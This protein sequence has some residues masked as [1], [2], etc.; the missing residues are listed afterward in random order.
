MLIRF[1]EITTN[2]VGGVY[3]KE[4]FINPSTGLF[5]KTSDIGKP[6]TLVLQGEYNFD[7]TDN[8]SELVIEV[9]TPLLNYPNRITHIVAETNQVTGS[10]NSIRYVAYSVDSVEYMGFS[11]VKFLLVE[12]P[13]ISHMTQ[14]VDSNMLINR[15]NDYS[16]FMSHDISDLAYSR[17]REDIDIGVYDYTG[18]WV[19][20]TLAIN[21]DDVDIVYIKFRDLEPDNYEQFSTLGDV[22]VKYPE[23]V[24]KSPTAIDYYGKIVATGAGSLY[25]AQYIYSLNK[26]VWRRIPISVPASEVNQR[27]VMRKAVTENFGW[28]GPSVKLITGDMLTLNFAF[29]IVDNIMSYGVIG[30]DESGT[31]YGYNNIPCADRLE[32]FQIGNV[33]MDS[34]IISKR[35]VT[36]IAFNEQGNHRP[37][38]SDG[39]YLYVKNNNLVMSHNWSYGENGELNTFVPIIKNISSIQKFNFSITGTSKVT[40]HEPFANYYLNVFGQNIPIKSKF[41]SQDI[42]IKSAISSTSWSVTVYVNNTNNVI[43]SGRI[44]AEIPYSLDKFQDFLAQNSTYTS[45]KWVNTML[46]GGSRIG[47]SAITGM[48]SGNVGAGALSVGTGIAS[49]GQD[50]TNMFLQEKAMK[51]A[52]DVIKGDGND[53]GTIDINPY[54]IY[55]YA[56]VP[57][58]DALELMKT[59][60]YANGFPTSYVGKIKDLA[61][62]VNDIYGP[63]KLVRGRLV[64]MMHNYHITNLLNNRLNEGIVILES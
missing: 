29:P 7:A 58:A 52:P 22:L 36:G 11:Q 35:I 24:T 31:V 37:A 30:H 13:V 64:G 9:N 48:L 55:F 41:A 40:R 53:F 51:D 62:S 49:L 34:Y 4:D 21:I 56:M 38:G 16:K 59:E 20:Y 46:G 27:L 42:F 43:W 12:D 18:K 45:S 25:Q 5:W 63:C 8:I 32:Y 10:A 17:V 50:I 2:T 23:V 28:V 15:T 39:N 19:V 33:K 47:K 14:L 57:T 1:Y 44:S 26:I 60:L 6:S 61:W 3:R 54:G